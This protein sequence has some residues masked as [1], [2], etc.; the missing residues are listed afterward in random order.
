MS[1]DELLRA[2]LEL[3][4]P[5]EAFERAE[6]D[7][8]G[9][10]RS[11]QVEAERKALRKKFDKRERDRVVSELGA[12]ITT[13]AIFVGI[14]AMTGAGYFWP[15]WMLFFWGITMVGNLASLVLN[16]VKKERRF[17]RWLKK[18]QGDGISE[19]ANQVDSV[20][21]EYLATGGHNRRRAIEYYRDK[22][23][24]DQDEAEEL[25]QEYMERH[26]GVL[27]YS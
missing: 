24:V 13:N 17:E 20:L 8:A 2:A 6:Q 12:F 10:R 23:G 7:L 26:P 27:K 5:P 19:E 18:Q 15:G 4:I 1:R 16:P 21:N 25:V 9:Q 11:L 22:M 14:W 3:G